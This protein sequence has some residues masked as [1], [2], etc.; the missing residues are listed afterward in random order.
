[1]ENKEIRY[2]TRMARLQHHYDWLNE[3]KAQRG[4]SKCGEDR[5]YVLQFHHTDPSRKEGSISSLINSTSWK[6]VL[7][8]IEKCDVLCANCHMALHHKERTT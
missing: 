5:G 7:E 6:N 1:M 4:C 3:Y 2:A 8:E